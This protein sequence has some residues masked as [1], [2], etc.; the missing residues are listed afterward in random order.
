[1]NVIPVDTPPLNSKVI[2]KPQLCFLHMLIIYKDFFFL[3]WGR[4][5]MCHQFVT[6]PRGLTKKPAV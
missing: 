1:M 6:E 2:I 5:G 4:G 3:M